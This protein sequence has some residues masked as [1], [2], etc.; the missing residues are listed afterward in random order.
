MKKILTAISVSGLLAGWA[1]AQP[2][3]AIT[4][5]GA[6]PGGTYSSAAVVTNNSSVTGTAARPD[7]TMHAVIWQKKV[8][9]D[10][11]QFASPE[12]TGRNSQASGM[13]ERGQVSGEAETAIPEANGEDFCGFRAL[14]LPSLGHTCLP[15]IAQN[16]VMAALPTL[17]GAN[18][19]AY[20]I[21]N[22]GQVVGFA[23]NTTR[24]P[25][26]GAPQ[27]F[28]FKPVMWD[29][30][31]ATELPTFPGDLNGYA[32]GIN[33]SGQVT[34]ASGSCTT[35]NP[36]SQNYLITSHALL[37]QDGKR[38]DLGNLGGTGTFNGNQACAINNRGQIAGQSDLKGDTTGHAFLWENGVIHDLGTLH[39]D[40]AAS[41][42]F[43]INDGGELVGLGLDAEFNPSAILWENRLPFDLNSL[44]RSNPSGLY[45]Q[46][47][48]AINARG[49]ITGFG[50]TQNGETHAYLATP[51]N[52][53]TANVRFETADEAV[54]AKPLAPSE[55]SRKLLQRRLRFGRLGAR[56]SRSK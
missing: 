5:L 21:N 30:G 27:Q 38:T 39:P 29:H 52:G 15:F 19:S 47:A 26:C 14:G 41:L 54:V 50:Q 45:L 34:G 18:G 8:M 16:G 7:G 20:Q 25:A 4:D 49:E 1:T 22:S 46:L 11:T 42:A 6:L 35:F 10:I 13:N 24:D 51:V 48:E 28:Q 37:W 12:L 32:F 55:T 53:A 56:L 31:K 40:D 9:T 44:V 43:G 2:R 33:D 36:N 23:E 17:G 3:Y